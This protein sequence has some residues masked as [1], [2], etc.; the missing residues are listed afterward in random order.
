[1]QKK[2]EKENQSL[3]EQ[4]KIRATENEVDNE[5]KNEKISKEEKLNMKQKNK[6]CSA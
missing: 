5:A 3:F 6:I 2:K 1:M 4:K